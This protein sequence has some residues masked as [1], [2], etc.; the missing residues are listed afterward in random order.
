[1][2]QVKSFDPK[3]NFDPDF[4]WIYRNQYKFKKEKQKALQH[5]N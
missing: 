5:P 3:Y 2:S 1:M 4:P